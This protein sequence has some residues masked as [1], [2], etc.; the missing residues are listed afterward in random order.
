MLGVTTNPDVLKVCRILFA[1]ASGK[2]IFAWNVHY[3]YGPY[4]RCLPLIKINKK[5]SLRQVTWHQLNEY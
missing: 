2:H 1:T 5:S 3:K 4:L